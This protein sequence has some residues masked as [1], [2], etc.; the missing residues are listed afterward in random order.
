MRT[1]HV[2]FLV[3]A[4]RRNTLRKPVGVLTDRDIVIQIDARGADPRSLRVGE[5]MT[6]NLVIASEHDDLN[7][8]IQALRLGG[9]RRAPVVDTSGAL[10]E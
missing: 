7:E 6:S 4:R 1:Q 9:I 5:V 3:V 2:G 10:V 8:L